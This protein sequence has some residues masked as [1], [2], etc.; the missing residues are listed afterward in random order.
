MSLTFFFSLL[1]STASTPESAG[2]LVSKATTRT[3]RPPFRRAVAA[4]ARSRP[5]RVSDVEVAG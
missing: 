1:A 3:H 4:A 5:R 2:D